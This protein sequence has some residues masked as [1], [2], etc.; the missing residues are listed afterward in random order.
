M[1]RFVKPA[2]FGCLIGIA[3]VVAS[4]FH[5]AHDIEE[6]IGLGLL[7]KLRGVR[8]ASSDVAIVSIDRES[9]EHLDVSDNPNRWPR[10]LHAQLVENLAR[11]G[12]QVIIFD[13]YFTESHSAEEDNAFAETIKRARNVVLAEP[14]KVKEISSSDNGKPSAR[15]HRIVQIV[16]PIALL[17]QSAVATAPFV[18]PRMPVNVN[19]YWSFQ[20]GAGDSP[21]FPIVAFQL[22]AL[23][24]YDEFVRLLEKVSPLHA[25]KLPRDADTAITTRGAVR[26]VRDIRG[27]FE[28]DPSISK[29]MLDELERSNPAASDLNKS[30][31]L[32]SLIKLY[33]GADRRYLN[34]Y[35]PPRTVTTIP[36]YR[37]LRLRKD[38]GIDSRI[39]LR[40]RAVFVGR[41]E[42][43]LTEREDSYYTVFS[44]TND[45]FVS[46]VEI[47]AT[48]FSNLV[49]DVFVQPIG[50]YHYIL[51][52]LTWGI[53]AGV[54]CRMAAIVMAA[55]GIVGASVLYLIAVE[56]QFRANGA[57][58]PVV[59]PLFLQSPLAF[60][61]AVLW[62]YFET[63]KERENIGRALG[64][65]V[66]NEVAHQLATNVVDMK[67]GGQT[68]YGACL[69][70]DAAGY[71][72]LSETMD[73]K[74][75]RD[76][77]HKYFEATFEPVKRNGGLI[78]DLKGDSILAIWKAAQPEP[79]L[80][81]QACQAALDVAK[82]VSRFN[83]S[84]ET[85]RLPTR[86]GVHSG[87]IFLGNI[88][89]GDH[90]RYGPT[91]DTVNTASRIDSLNKFLGTELLVSE[92]VIHGLEG[93]LTREVGRFQLKGKAQALV[94]HE[95]FCRME[96]SEERQKKACAIF[97]EA[98]RAFRRQS[99]DEAS[100]KFHQA[101]RHAAT[102]GPALYYI[103]LCEQYK[104]NPPEG[105]WEG[106]IPLEEK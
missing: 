53:L 59:I 87:Q 91:G 29:K 103:N 88:G 79:A 30:K 12:A 76:Y 77:M 49:D 52:I 62:N 93:F 10:S 66:P 89:A 63:N 3:G 84:F 20:T 33:G 65:Y 80:R 8:K 38:A 24:A 73:P 15:E 4:V 16:K 102:D 104:R 95:L 61:G 43:L 105:E 22:Y 81:K 31:L 19:Q 54:M 41:S 40:G 68:V 7:F 100:D 21:T 6:N 96:E 36:F 50:P 101:L 55:L 78:V 64:Y 56:Y 37:A 13:V 46:G 67:R 99:W 2:Y 34:H 9:S 83:R 45:T 1:A 39:D 70:T 69:F 44:E 57:W 11:E 106:V 14:L 28:S 72:N 51:L 26:F 27:I 5:F 35:G 42:L 75:L 60:F 85:L 94:V 48:A 25:G 47:A 58:Y 86:V 18:L 23:R 17:A 97:S 74:E 71:T 32:R 82:A 98:L 92:E 90:Y